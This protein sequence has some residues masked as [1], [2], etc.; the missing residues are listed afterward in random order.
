MIWH[1]SS[2]AEPEPDQEVLGAVKGKLWHY[3]IYTYKGQDLWYYDGVAI[4]PPLLW[5]EII[6]PPVKSVWQSNAQ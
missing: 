3:G 5:T 6:P 2:L 1:K 4:D